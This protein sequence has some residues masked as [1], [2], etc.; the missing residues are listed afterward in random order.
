MLGNQSRDSGLSSY[1]GGGG[2][3]TSYTSYL[4]YLSYVFSR[5]PRRP[6][7]LPLI[8]DTQ[9]TVRDDAGDGTEVIRHAAE[10]DASGGPLDARAGQAVPTEARMMAPFRMPGSERPAA[11][12][13]GLALAAAC[14]GHA[15]LHD[16]PETASETASEAAS[17]PDA[18]NLTDG[19]CDRRC[20]AADGV[21]T[22]ALDGAGDACKEDA[23][24]VDLP[25]LQDLE[26]EAPSCNCPPPTLLLTVNAIPG[27]MNGSKPFL[28]NV[29]EL[30]PFHLALPTHGFEV[31][32]EV[33][34][35]CGCDGAWPESQLAF[36]VAAGELAAGANLWDLIQW[37]GGSEANGTWSTGSG[38]LWVGGDLELAVAQEVMIHASVRDV[39][40]QGSPVTSLQVETVEMTPMLHPFDI[41]DP[42]LLT[43]HRDHYTITLVQ[44]G[45]ESAHVEA[46]QAANGVDDFVEDMWTVG[47]GSPTPTAEFAAVECE[48][49]DGGN[50]CLV[51]EL[52]RRSI[53][54]AYKPFLCAPD[55]TKGPG[56]VNIRFYVEGALGAPDPA[57]FEYEFLDQYE[58]GVPPEGKA[59]SIIGFGGGDLSKSW[60]GMSETV[61]VHNLRN[62]NNGKFGYGCF[63]TSIV[64]FFY[65]YLSEDPN[66]YAL[67]KTALADLLPVMGGMA[68][69]E[70]PGDELVIDFAVAD[71][72]LPKELLMRRKTL[73]T[74]LDV[75]ATGLGA[76]AAHEIGH[77]IGLVPKGAPP[78]GLFAGEQNASFIANPAGS[79]GPH[80]DTAGPNLMQAGPGSG[81]NKLDISMLLTP[82]FFNELN[83][84]YL[85]GR[86]VVK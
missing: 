76:L 5:R 42:W 47:L 7:L 9:S 52:L 82:F 15:A 29:G 14:S 33:E 46:V 10:P 37:S 19:F 25:A 34:C 3:Y 54:K 71:E 41:E 39:C 17:T 59:F 40:G 86:L 35:P 50:E 18:W 80:I 81:N 62:E 79:V 73:D 2:S 66:L 43:Y 12:F 8:I 65:E 16:A 36:N 83:L 49:G 84:A 11:L 13:A 28:N 31:N 56:S 63:T 74:L 26:S 67:A 21:A 20:Q 30:E 32:L 72:D 45:P 1:S 55:G 70:Q 6:R 69:G 77:S 53:E 78:T 24:A 23:E 22:E 4:S 85:Q 44:D 60:V 38:S 58:G 57:A 64:R 61:D 48:G 51:R 75:F 68:V 27:D